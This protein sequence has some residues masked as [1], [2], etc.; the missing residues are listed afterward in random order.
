MK[1]TTSTDRSRSTAVISYRLD[2]ETANALSAEAEKL[3]LSSHELA[4][5]ILLEWLTDQ[6][7][8]HLRRSLSRVRSELLKL[9][10]DLKE[11]VTAILCDAGKLEKEDAEAWVSSRL[12]K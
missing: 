11:S 12:F 5:R 2:A 9:R 6:E 3:G 4:R 7:R 10:A 8:H 1:P